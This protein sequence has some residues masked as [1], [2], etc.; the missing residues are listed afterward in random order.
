MFK[1]LKSQQLMLDVMKSYREKQNK[2]KEGRS[3]RGVAILLREE[4]GKFSLIRRHLIMES[5]KVSE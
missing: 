2:V 4:S 1:L 3:D 5:E